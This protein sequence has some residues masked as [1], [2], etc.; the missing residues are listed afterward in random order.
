MSPYH[1][2]PPFP[3]SS[4]PI[5]PLD[6]QP[7]R[8]KRPSPLSLLPLSDYPHRFSASSGVFSN[9]LHPHGLAPDY[10]RSVPSDWTGDATAVC[11]NTS[12]LG[13]QHTQ[14]TTG[15]TG[16]T[17]SSP[18][19]PSRSPASTPA[20]WDSGLP[21]NLVPYPLLTQG[22]EG[23]NTFFYRSP[24]PS[25]RQRTNQ[26]CEKCRDRKTKVFM[27]SHVMDHQPEFNNS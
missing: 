27:V 2:G 1:Q 15:S 17:S 5:L 9:G 25:A 10:A 13:P 11:P 8:T 19:P 24:T 14:S 16:V 21:M 20:G 4:S 18:Y 3:V 7:S 26:A 23:G 22:S 12:E 6:V